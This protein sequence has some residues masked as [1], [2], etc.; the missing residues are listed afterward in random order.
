[1]ARWERVDFMN[2]WFAGTWMPRLELDLVPGLRCAA[3]FAIVADTIP[4]GIDDHV[5]AGVATQRFWLTATALGLQLQPQYTPLVFAACARR[6][7]AFTEVR[8]ALTRAA[9]VKAR[10]DELLGERRG[11]SAV[12]MGRIGYGEEARSR[13]L[14]LPL[15]ALRWSE[16]NAR[17]R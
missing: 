12:F 8:A 17:D 3:H 13:S 4:Q 7:H 14:R 6:Q 10:L 2:R 15:E 5:A 11:E 16:S 9:D 1:M